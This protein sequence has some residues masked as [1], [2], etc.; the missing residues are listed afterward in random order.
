MGHISPPEQKRPT[1]GGQGRGSLA[2]CKM[3][4]SVLPGK[5]LFGPELSCLVQGVVGAIYWVIV[6]FPSSELRRDEAGDFAPPG[7]KRV[8]LATQI[9]LI[10]FQK[11]TM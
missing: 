3:G 9:I 11:F 6:V 10:V 1:S 2:S 7:W 4:S 5:M 8:F